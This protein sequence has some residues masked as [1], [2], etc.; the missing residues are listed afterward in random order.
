M[1]MAHPVFQGK[2]APA[3]SP[4]QR[5]LSLIAFVIFVATSCG[6]SLRGNC[7]RRSVQA[8]RNDHLLKVSRRTKP[9]E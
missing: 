2:K 9:R 6:L 3:P 5:W 1:R 4:N 7:G 8:V